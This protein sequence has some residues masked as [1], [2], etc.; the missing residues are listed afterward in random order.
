MKI[1]NNGD[2]FSGIRKIPNFGNENLGTENPEK[3]ASLAL[4]FDISGYCEK[5]S[6]DPQNFR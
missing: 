4:V 1:S 6:P 3:Y 2:H 5:I